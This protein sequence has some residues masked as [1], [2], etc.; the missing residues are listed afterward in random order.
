MRLSSDVPRVTLSNLQNRYL[1]IS[2]V[3]ES[4]PGVDFG[5]SRGHASPRANGRHRAV[6]ISYMN[7]DKMTHQHLSMV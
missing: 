7:N 6:M 1:W 2:G 5:V 4:G 3:Q